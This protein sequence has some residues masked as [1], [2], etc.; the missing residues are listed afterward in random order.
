MPLGC[1]SIHVRIQTPTCLERN[2]RKKKKIKSVKILS[3]SGGI[4]LLKWDNNKG[5]QLKD[6]DGKA[7]PYVKKENNIIEFNTIKSGEYVIE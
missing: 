3:K 6:K 4:C 1:F 2:R 7:V 5:P